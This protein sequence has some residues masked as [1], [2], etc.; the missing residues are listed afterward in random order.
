MLERRRRLG[1]DLFDEV[2]EGVLHMNPRALRKT[3]TDRGRCTRSCRPPARAA[4]LSEHR[5]VQPRGRTRTTTESPMAGCTGEARR[6]YIPTA[7]LVI[8]IVSPGDETWEKLD[9]YAAHGGG[10]AADRRSAGEVGQLAGARTGRVQAPEAKPADRARRRRARRA[11]RLAVVVT[12]STAK[13]QSRRCRPHALLAEPRRAAPSTSHALQPPP[14]RSA[15]CCAARRRG[16]L[17]QS[18]AS[19]SY[20]GRAAR[21][22]PARFDG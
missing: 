1:Q 15:S 20:H 19:S 22:S 10:G 14:R 11:D 12:T 6:V 16:E 3:R 21:A 9:F 4:G 7:A 13:P 8:E 5:T 17:P 18:M 2:W